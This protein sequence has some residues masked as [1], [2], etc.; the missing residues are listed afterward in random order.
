MQVASCARKLNVAPDLKSRR[1]IFLCSKVG[2]KFSPHNCFALEI[3]RSNVVALN[4]RAPNRQHSSVGAQVSRAQKSCA[5]D[6]AFSSLRPQ[7][8]QVEY[9][10][11]L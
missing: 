5:E 4:C 2:A 3:L 1:S 7:A 6:L 9:L 10:S 11:I 8:E